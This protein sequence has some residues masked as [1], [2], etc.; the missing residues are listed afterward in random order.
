[1]LLPGGYKGVAPSQVCRLHKSLYGFKQVSREWN[2]EFCSRIT[3]FGY[4]Q[5]TNDFCLFMKHD[6]NEHTYLLVYVDDVIIVG[7]SNNEIQ[8]VKSIYIINSMLKILLKP[9]TSFMLR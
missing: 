7:N 9:S 3:N 4:I 5:S 2:F 8:K 1:M 6:K